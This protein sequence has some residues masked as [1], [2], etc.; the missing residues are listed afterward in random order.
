MASGDFNWFDYARFIN[1]WSQARQDK[2]NQGFQQTPMSPEQRAVWQYAFDKFKGSP[3]ASADIYPTARYYGTNAPS[4][5]VDAMKAGK[6]GYKPVPPP[7]PAQLSA[8]I[9]GKGTESVGTSRSSDPILN[10]PAGSPID[11]GPRNQIG[12]D[13]EGSTGFG[14]TIADAIGR[15]NPRVSAGNYYQPQTPTST[16]STAGLAPGSPDGTAFKQ[17][18]ATYGRA[19]AMAILAIMTQ[20]PGMAFGAA[21]QAWR[22]HQASGQPQGGSGGGFVPGSIGGSHAGQ[23]FGG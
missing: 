6:T 15:D 13:A 1:D 7:T 3:D 22:A 14:N 2:K 9:T 4:I 10:T 5:D 11:R 17:F 16:G 12:G 21:V 20:N 18:M 8:I 23:S 19:A